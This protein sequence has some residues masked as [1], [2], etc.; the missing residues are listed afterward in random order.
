MDCGFYISNNEENKLIK[1]ENNL[2]INKK[3]NNIIINKKENNKI[4]NKKENNSFYNNIYYDH[5][6]ILALQK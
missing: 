6:G 1:K 3:E 5:F 4:I 2:I